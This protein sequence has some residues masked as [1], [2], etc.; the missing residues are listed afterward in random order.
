MT[1]SEKKPS[2]FTPRVMSGMRPTGRLHLGHWLGVLDNWVKLQEQYEC[3]FM[4]ADWHALTTKCHETE[5]LI[6]NIYDIALDWLAVG[7]DPEKSTMYV[8]SAIPEEAEMHL[9]LSMFT[10][11]KWLE[12][13]PTLKDMVALQKT[14]TDDGLNYGL[15]GYPILQTVDILAPKGTLVPI[16]KDQEAH[17]EVSRDIARRINHL[18][19]Q[20]IFP[21]PRPLFTEVSRLIGLDGRKMS[22]SYDNAIYLADDEE[23]TLKKIKSAMT[24]PGRVKRDDP[25]V[26]ENCQGIYPYY[27]IFASE[28]ATGVTAEECRQA[29]RG[30]I[31]CKKALADIVNERLRPI[32]E[33]RA[34]YAQDRAQVEAILKT[35]SEKARETCSA[36]LNELKKAMRLYT[37]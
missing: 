33:R 12:T 1:D 37:R 6:D 23:T 31:D 27:Q 9:L 5:D 35:G 17:L 10:P 20:E 18:L 28:E 13:D 21:E 22:K 32:R 26:P 29:S 7:V 4:V 30:C 8:Q 16:G 3:F 2:Q 25:G 36:T 34:L 15:L 14:G 24:D 11:V 19:G